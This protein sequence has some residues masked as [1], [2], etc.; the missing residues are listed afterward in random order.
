M[1][2]V[3]DIDTAAKEQLWAMVGL[4]TKGCDCPCH[5]DMGPSRGCC[6]EEH[7]PLS[8]RVWTLPGMQDK[9]LGLKQYTQSVLGSLVWDGTFEG[10]LETDCLVCHGSGYVVKRDPWGTVELLSYHAIR[11]RGVSVPG[12]R[13]YATV[14]LEG[15][16]GR[17][18]GRS[19]TSKTEALL[20][21]VAKALLAHGATLGGGT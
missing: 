18:G 7:I 8:G 17:W 19:D 21:A 3:V 9:C 20:R 14:K 5:T 13:Y 2:K 15:K 16:Q 1:P 4:A 6:E 12:G 10:C 11:D